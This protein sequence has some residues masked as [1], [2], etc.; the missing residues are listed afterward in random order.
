[1]AITLGVGPTSANNSGGAG[2]TL[3][4]VLNGTTTGR[5]LVVQVG[6]YS[7]SDYPLPNIVSITCSGEANL[8]VHGTPAIDDDRRNALQLASLSNITSGGNKT[9]EV[10]MSASI[11]ANALYIVAT[12]FAGGNTT[13]FF[14]SWAQEGGKYTDAAAV[15]AGIDVTNDN[16]MLYAAIT[17]PYSG[18][19]GTAGTNFT[20]LIDEAPAWIWGYAEYDLDAGTAGIKTAGVTRT[21]TDG[22]SMAVA[23]FNPSGTSNTEITI[24][25]GPVEAFGS[26]TSATL[27][28]TLKGTTSG[29]QIIVGVKWDAAVTISSITCSGESNLTVHGSPLE[30]YNATDTYIQL[31]SLADITTGGDKTITV[32]MSGSVV[33]DGLYMTALEVVGGDTGGFYDTQTTAV[34][35]S[36]SPSVN[37]T[38]TNDDSLIIGF[39]GEEAFNNYGKP[40]TNFAELIDYPVINAGHVFMVARWNAGTAGSK[41]VGFTKIE[42]T[43][44]DYMI[45]AAAFNSG[46]GASG[47]KVFEVTNAALDITPQLPISD[48]TNFIA[49]PAGSLTLTGLLPGG[50]TGVHYGRVFLQGNSP[51]I[52]LGIPFVSDVVGLH[53]NTHH[54]LDLW[55]AKSQKLEEG[56]VYI[57]LLNANARFTERLYEKYRFFSSPAGAL[58]GLVKEAATPVVRLVRA[59]RRSDGQFVGSATSDGG[60]GAYSIPNLAPNVE[61]FVL[62]FDDDDAIVLNALV[63]DRVETIEQK[64]IPYVPTHLNMHTHAPSIEFLIPM[65]YKYWRIANIDV[66]GGN[67]FEISEIRVLSGATD[68]TSIATKSSSDPPQ[69][70]TNLVD[71]FD[72]DLFTRGAVWVST[73]VEDPYFWIGLEFPE[74]ADITGVKQGGYNTADRYMQG[75]VLQYSSDGVNFYTKGVKSGLVYPGNNTMSNEYTFP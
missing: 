51:S 22:W 66:A 41:T 57:G 45:I 4:V 36:G 69:F 70:G 21:D 18:N 55:S 61:Y 16:V 31:A 59:Y 19:A 25:S 8:K 42:N 43:S 12:E 10:T 11:V 30:D 60:T 7:T 13:D 34:G 40:G 37:I 52:G 58:S 33:N 39:G 28:L 5:Q 20:E 50:F 68:I 74:K 44:N 71:L 29:N 26:T 73:L 67:N 35:A 72:N 23:A 38:P 17:G 49:V 65:S 64:I 6:W 15:S 54:L 46:A 32:T 3:Q 14:H 2:T 53:A 63:L 75:F 24:G 27:A 9:I 1:M 47:D 48:A 62:A 56:Q